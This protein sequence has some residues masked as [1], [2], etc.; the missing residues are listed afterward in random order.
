ML[1]MLV[2]VE[3]NHDHVLDVW[4]AQ[5]NPNPSLVWKLCGHTLQFVI[6]EHNKPCSEQR[7]GQVKQSK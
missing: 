4:S 1:Q 6:S 7:P 5:V 2:E 3:R